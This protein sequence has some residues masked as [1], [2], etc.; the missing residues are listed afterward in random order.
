MRSVAALVAAL[1]VALLP[2]AGFAQS[3]TVLEPLYGEKVRTSAEKDGETTVVCVAH[4]AVSS[5]PTTA[6]KG[7]RAVEIQNNGT[8]ALWCTVDGSD[9]VA[10]TNGRKVSASPDSPWALDAGSAITI[11]CIAQTSTQS[12]GACTTITELR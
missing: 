7:R 11:K 8:T 4:N 2:I 3:T 9:P 5:M 6:L 1:A 10:T 12:S